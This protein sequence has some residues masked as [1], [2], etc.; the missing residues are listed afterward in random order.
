VVAGRDPA[1]GDETIEIAHEALIRGWSDLKG[2]IDKDREFLLWRQQLRPFLEKWRRLPDHKDAAL[3]QGIY[4]AEARQWLRQRP[5]DLS[6]EERRFILAS[7]KPGL[8][9]RRWKQI[10][11]VAAFLTVVAAAGGW[12]WTGRD[13]YQVQAT[14][15]EAKQAVVSAELFGAEPWLAALAYSGK[16]AEALSEGSSIADEDS[17]AQALAKTA[18]ALADSGHTGEAA[19]AAQKVLAAPGSSTFASFNL[20]RVA[21]ALGKA[22][23]FHDALETVSRVEPTVNRLSNRDA[24]TQAFAGLA[25]AFAERGQTQLVKEFLAR[26]GNPVASEQCLAETTRALAEAGQVEDSLQLAKQ[27]NDSFLSAYAKG[28]VAEALARS[29]KRDEAGR[30]AREALQLSRTINKEPDRSYSLNW[31]VRALAEAGETS[32]ALSVANGIQEQTTHAQALMDIAERLARF[33]KPAEA[34]DL[35]NHVQQQYRSLFYGTLVTSLARAKMA[36]QAMDMVS[37]LKKEGLTGTNTFG[38]VVDPGT[39]VELL[40]EGKANAKDALAVAQQIDEPWQ[41]AQALARVSVALKQAGELQEAERIAEQALAGTRADT[42]ASGK[43]DLKSRVETL[44]TITEI[45]GNAGMSKLSQ[46]AAS[47]ALE[48]GRAITTDE[49]RS[50]AFST[51]A[52]AYAKLH[53]YR[54]ARSVADQCTKSDHKLAV[55]AAIL[56]EYA[57]HRHPEL[58][59]LFARDE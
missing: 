22:G 34:I 11:A 30:I 4:L 12:W 31:T 53:S 46:S 54:R 41:R 7:E 23:R 43:R 40:V 24:R 42:K 36:R 5:K 8:G 21:E 18:V 51:I 20:A 50:D 14:L 3:L 10:A 28:G 25:K 29:G 32:E 58:A 16:A 56:R 15:R 59:T 17:R 27:I 13:D 47:L 57:L 6:G 2:W 49:D 48:T 55:Y 37:L 26:P 44:S 52:Q 19:Q 9:T 38:W 1:T 35:A 45:L 39:V 33:G